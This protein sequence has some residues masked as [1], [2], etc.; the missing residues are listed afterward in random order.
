MDPQIVIAWAVAGIF[1]CSLVGLVVFC[2]M[3]VRT[4]RL[5]RKMEIEIEPQIRALRQSLNRI[6]ALAE[7]TEGTMRNSVGPVFNNVEAATHSIRKSTGSVHSMV[8]RI[9]DA[10]AKPIA[11]LG[12]AGD[13]L[14][15]PAG[16]AGLLALVLGASKIRQMRQHA[17]SKPS[18]EP[19]SKGRSNGATAV[20]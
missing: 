15:T 2:G 4:S 9:E 1:A 18:D 10:A 3:A 12:A 7:S 6:E 11:I 17:A 20:R 8:Q 16:K 5:A 13:A 19:I 14:Q